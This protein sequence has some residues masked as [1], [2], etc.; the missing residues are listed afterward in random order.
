M[1]YK[2]YLL[3]FSNYSNKNYLNLHQILSTTEISPIS[4][5]GLDKG[6]TGQRGDRTKGGPDKGGTGQR[7]DRT[8]GGP[9]KGGTG[10]RVL[11]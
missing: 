10:Q 2:I 3:N 5:G 1:N 4:W 11:R 7:G 9:D 8:K 6:G